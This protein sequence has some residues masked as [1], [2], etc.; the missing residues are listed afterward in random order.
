MSSSVSNKFRFLDLPAELRNEVYRNLLST[1]Y[2]KRFDEVTC[3][4]FY[5]L[6]LSILRTNRQIHTEALE[7]FHDNQFVRITCSWLAFEDLLAE[8]KFPLIGAKYGKARNFTEHP[9]KQH[10]MAV[11]LDYMEDKY[12]ELFITAITCQEDVGEFC[13]MLYYF[14][15]S[16]PGF[17]QHL[18]ITLA[19]QDPHQPRALSPEMQRSLLTPFGMLKDLE[20]A[21]FSGYITPSVAL[22]VQEAMAIPAPTPEQSLEHATVLKDAGNAALQAGNYPLSISKYHQAYEAMHITVDGRRMIIRLE[23]FSTTLQGGMYDGQRLDHVRHVLCARLNANIVL[24]YLKMADYHNAYFWGCRGVQGLKNQNGSSVLSGAEK[25]R[26]YYR[27]AL[28]SKGLRK[29]GSAVE[30]LEEALELV[31]GDATIRTELKVLKKLVEGTR[32]KRLKAALSS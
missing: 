14:D 28:A 26:L 16:S 27:R 12:E 32:Q 17:N 5:D 15:C 25:A 2:N 1:K 6:Q 4:F 19:V 22:E 9:F 21:Q 10:H 3:A 31:P 18:F 29:H 30:D 13:K 23:G 8:A 7:V 24:A 11:I 20:G